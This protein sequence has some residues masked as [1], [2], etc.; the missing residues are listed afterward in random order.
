[1]A[2]RRDQLQ[3]YQFMVERVVAA[4]LTREPDPAQTPPRRGVGAVFAGVMVAVIVA[5]GYGVFGILTK[6]GDEAWK[7]D[8]SVVLEKETGAVYLYELGVLHPVLNLS[9]A[10]LLSG[11]AMGTPTRVPAKSLASVPR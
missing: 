11:K 9:S 10:L 6:T 4:L 7:S 3:S 8:G 1:M 5:A 2:S